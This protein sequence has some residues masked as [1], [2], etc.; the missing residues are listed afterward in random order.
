MEL[1]NI[2]EYPVKNVLNALLKDKTTRKN[3]IR[4][5]NLCFYERC[6]YYGDIIQWAM[7]AND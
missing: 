1:I 7:E 4:Q 3:N 2:K 5:C 6:A